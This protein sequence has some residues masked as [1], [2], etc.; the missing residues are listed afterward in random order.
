MP[1]EV[2]DGHQGGVGIEKLGGHGVPQ[3]VTGDLEPGLV[4][5]MFQALLD[6][7]HRDGLTPTSAFVHQKNLFD[8][9]GRPHPQILDQ[10]LIGI[11]AQVDH[12]VLGALAIVDNDWHRGRYG[13]GGVAAGAVAVG[14]VVRAVSST[15]RPVVYGGTTYYV[16]GNTC[17][18]PCYQGDEAAYCV[19][20]NPSP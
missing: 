5:V 16:D 13:Y 9:A 19:V 12:P 15:A 17:Y 2:L 7:P 11:S 4:G 20:Q 10:G 18:K 3:L 1:Q 8:P 6:A 14:T